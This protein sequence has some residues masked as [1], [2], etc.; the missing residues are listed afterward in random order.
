MNHPKSTKLQKRVLVFESYIEYC[1]GYG[2]R[3]EL[4]SAIQNIAKKNR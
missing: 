2:G 4:T 1:L 3:Q